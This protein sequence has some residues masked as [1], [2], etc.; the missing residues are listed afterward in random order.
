MREYYL[1]LCKYK[2]INKQT[3]YRC[4]KSLNERIEI[5]SDKNVSSVQQFAIENIGRTLLNNVEIE[6]LIPYSISDK[7]FINKIDITGCLRSTEDSDNTIVDDGIHYNYILHS[8]ED[9]TVLLDCLNEN[10]ND[11]K[12]KKISCQI[13][14]EEFIQSAL[15]NITLFINSNTLRKLCLQV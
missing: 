15:I 9:N 11:V 5:L 14:A 12:C 7:E 10:I 2:R 13:M 6:L 8:D 1:Y 4:R 3:I